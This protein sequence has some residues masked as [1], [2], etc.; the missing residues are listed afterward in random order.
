[1]GR[2]SVGAEL[3][4]SPRRSLLLFGALASTLVLF[5]GTRYFVCAEDFSPKLA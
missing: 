4:H 5:G 1:M 3:Q 2:S